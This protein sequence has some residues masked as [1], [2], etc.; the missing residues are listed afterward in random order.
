MAAPSE[1]QAFKLNSGFT[2]TRL[3]HRC[4]SKDWERVTWSH[5]YL[6]D[7][8]QWWKFGITMSNLKENPKQIVGILSFLAPICLQE[9]G[10]PASSEAWRRLGPG[11][12]P[13]RPGCV[14]LR[15]PGLG[16]PEAVLLDFCHIFHLGYGQDIAASSVVLLAHLDHFDGCRLKHKLET[17]YVRFDEWCRA[18]GHTSHI[19]A[20]SRQAFGM[21][22]IL[23]CI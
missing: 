9:W 19:Q 5:W 6:K 17:A 3:C 2:S 10:N 18:H 8:H 15:V 20:F 23:I 14:L 13:F 4:T 12:S 21:S 1:L 16:T 22:S 11:P 7:A